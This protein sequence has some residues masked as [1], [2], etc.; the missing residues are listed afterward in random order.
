MI[1]L[2]FC[3]CEDSALTTQRSVTPAL[4]VVNP[5]S[6]ANALSESVVIEFVLHELIH[7]LLF[8]LSS[9]G[10]GRGRGIQRGGRDYLITGR[11]KAR[12]KKKDK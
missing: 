6:S 2:F 12:K 1:S 8:V 9:E 7:K 11:V 10:A 5:V 3:Y 4:L